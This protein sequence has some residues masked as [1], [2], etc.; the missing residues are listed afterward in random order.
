MRWA[1]AMTVKQKYKIWKVI[2]YKQNWKAQTKYVSTFLKAFFR[3]FFYFC[4][5]GNFEIVCSD[6]E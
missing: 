1:I 2:L 6:S 5:V 3:G 4:F